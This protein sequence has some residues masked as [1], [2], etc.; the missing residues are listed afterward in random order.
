MAASHSWAISTPSTS[1][2]FFTVKLH[3][4]D[5]A[6]K[7]VYSNWLYPIPW[8]NGNSGGGAS[9]CA[10]YHLYPISS[11]S[12]YSTSAFA[13]QLYLWSTMHRI[14]EVR[15]K[16]S[17]LVWPETWKVRAHTTHLDREGIY[18]CVYRELH[19]RNKLHRSTCVFTAANKQPE[20]LTFA[21]A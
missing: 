16:H 10:E 3:C 2:V 4:V 6:D 9:A 1:P 12:V 5:D 11:P 20:I 17:V 7:S 14:S 19:T 8:P 15:L 13:A 18:Y 21:Q